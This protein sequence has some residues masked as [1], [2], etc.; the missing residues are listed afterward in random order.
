MFAGLKQDE[1]DAYGTTKDF[2]NTEEG[3]EEDDAYGTTK[4]FQGADSLGN[5][6]SFKSSRDLQSDTS[7]LSFGQ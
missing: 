2:Q 4:D 6:P 7:P 3:D 1:G 5:L